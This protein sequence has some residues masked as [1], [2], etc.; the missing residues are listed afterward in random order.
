MIKKYL[1]RMA[2]IFFLAL[3]IFPISVIAHD[4]SGYL[5]V[6]GRYFQHEPRFPGQADN[7][8][9][10]TGYVEYY[11]DYDDRN[12]RIAFTGF[13][14]A[15]SEDSERSHGDIRELYWWKNFD[16]VEVYAGIRKIF[17]GV[18][19]SVHLVDIINQTDTL[20]NID[21]EDKLGQPMI[22]VVTAQNWGTLSAYIMPYF[23]E[24][25][26]PGIESRLRPGPIILDEERYQSDDEENHIDLALR[27]S[28]YI[29]IWDF[30]ISHFS[31][32]SRTP[33]F[34][35][36]VQGG[37]LIALQPIY[38][39]IEQTGIDVQATIDAW[40][41]KL[42]AISVYEKDF[43]RNSAFVSGVEYTFFTVGGT[44]ADL[45]IV[46]EYQFDDR[47]GFRQTIAQNDLVMGVRWAFNDIDASEILILASQDLDT[48]NRF[49]SAEVSRRLNDKWKIEA[50]ARVFSSAEV[51]TFD[52]DFR[53]DDYFQ[54]ELRR[55]F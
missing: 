16:S 53:D 13:A 45:G 2:S 5:G 46:A 32:T 10:L 28:H 44:N 18:A 12:Q 41:L 29:N 47:I 15:D 51:G 1:D 11:H 30:G 17:W 22:E 6:E 24:R 4:V 49:F 38:Q 7:N 37:N 35:P 19:E 33:V 26:F 14:R 55:Y 25:E 42:E 50:E 31:G 3:V 9:S 23:R 43:G 20:E 52:F 54:I 27:W 39:Q 8:A 40:L 21:G 36:V 48:S 34:E